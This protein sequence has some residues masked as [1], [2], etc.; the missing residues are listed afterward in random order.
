ME[1]S[2]E[3]VVKETE[4]T[5]ACASF[6]FSESGRHYRAARGLGLKSGS[7]VK[8]CSTGLRHGRARSGRRQIWPG[9]DPD[10]QP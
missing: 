9:G 8:W 5:P 1:L 4:P 10:V 2:S 7:A 3:Q 6:S